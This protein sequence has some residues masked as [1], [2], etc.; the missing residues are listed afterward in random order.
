MSSTEIPL[1]TQIAELGNIDAL[2]PTVYEELRELAGAVLHR[3]QP[4]DPTT[5][6][7]LIHNVYMRLAERDVRFKDKSHFLCLAARAMRFVLIDRARRANACKRAGDRSVITLEDAPAPTIDDA[8]MLAV[9]E[10]LNRLNELDERKSKMV[11]LRFFGGLSIEEIAE[12]MDL[13]PATIKREW[14]MARAWL[15]REIDR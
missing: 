13:S 15:G 7:S 2:L 14:A 11:E 6:T 5:T 4:I 12:V 1:G 3:C 8:Q 9:D 10:A